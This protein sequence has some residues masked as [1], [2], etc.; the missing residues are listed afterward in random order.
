LYHFPRAAR[1]WTGRER[2]EG[3]GGR[4]RRAEGEED[5]SSYVDVYDDDDD[6][7]RTRGDVDACMYICTLRSLS[8]IRGERQEIGIS[9]A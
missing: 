9:G 1:I 6:E 8:Y 3:G 2:G 7:E 5:G 4:R